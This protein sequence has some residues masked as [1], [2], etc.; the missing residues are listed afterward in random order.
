MKIDRQ[1]VAYNFSFVSSGVR[2]EKGTTVKEIFAPVII[3]DAGVINTFRKLLPP[4]VGEKSSEKY[5]EPFQETFIFHYP[6]F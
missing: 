6:Q 2:V 5:C 1:L 4:D 3:S